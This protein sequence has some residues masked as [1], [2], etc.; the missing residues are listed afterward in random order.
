MVANK[1]ACVAGAG[2]NFFLGQQ[3]AN[4][5]EPANNTISDK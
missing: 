5:I 4:K 1:I 3:A 2:Y